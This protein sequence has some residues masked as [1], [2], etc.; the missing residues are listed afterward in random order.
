MG[1][2]LPFARQAQFFCTRWSEVDAALDASAENKLSDHG[3]DAEHQ[4]SAGEP[5][6]A[7]KKMSLRSF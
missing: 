6:V 7:A 5:P 1:R 2:A 3:D 4:R